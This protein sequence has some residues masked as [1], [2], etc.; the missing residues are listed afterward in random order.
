[1]IRFPGFI[2]ICTEIQPDGW[3]YLSQKAMRCG[4]TA[5]IA[6][7]LPSEIYSER[8]DVLAAMEDPARHAACDY[9]KI[10]AVTPENIRTIAEWADEVPAVLLDFSIFDSAGSF[11]RMNM[12]SRLFS[13]WPAGKPICLR[14]DANQ[15]G[16]ALFMGQVH[17]KKI[18]ICSVSDRAAIEVI[19]EARKEG[20][21]V[22]CDIHPLAL[23]I[24]SDGK[25]AAGVLK[26]LGTEDDRQALWQHFGEIDCFSSAGYVGRHGDSA[27][28]L[29][30]MIPLLFS[31][32]KSEMITTE[33]ILLRCCLNPARI[34]GIR[35]DPE[36]SVEIDM[37][38]SAISS[39]NPVR[40]VRLH[41]Q[42]VFSA[43]S[44]GSG[45]KAQ[46]VQLKG[47]SA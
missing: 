45:I 22:T 24:S 34:F 7:P 13:R 14:G 20:I 19:S 39:G 3:E 43:D 25:N 18:H 36:T 21:S 4:Y 31:M 42:T 11:A 27:E 40:S 8:K 37:E 6:S 38:G 41:G 26:H 2:D 1:M 28:A 33:D 47:F 30:V 9:A 12:L 32:L 23:M 46:S 35:P 10:A 5:L 16:S 29:R 44:P 17:Q 15:I